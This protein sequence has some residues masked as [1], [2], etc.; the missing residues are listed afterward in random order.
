MTTDF[1]PLLRLLAGS[2]APGTRAVV[3]YVLLAQL[4]A[5]AGHGGPPHGPLRPHR[6]A[7]RP[8]GRK[9][10]HESLTGRRPRG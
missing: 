2:D 8:A 9:P 10:R 7:V 5:E 6:R 3:L 4:L 1:R